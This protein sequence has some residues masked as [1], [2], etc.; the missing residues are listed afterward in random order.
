MGNLHCLPSKRNNCIGGWC[1]H[2]IIGV[3]T[4]NQIIF[5]KKIRNAAKPLTTWGP[6]DAETFRRYHE[7][8]P[9][10]EVKRS[11]WGKIKNNIT[12]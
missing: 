5:F 7:Q 4:R 11:F 1:D 12:G 3:K 6:I 10:E 8:L 2:L 9:T